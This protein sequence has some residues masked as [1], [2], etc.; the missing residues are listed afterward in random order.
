LKIQGFIVSDA[1]LG[2]R[3]FAEHQEKLS[4]WIADGS[5][6]AKSSVT[7]GLDNA[8]EGFIGMLAGKNFGKAVL[9]IAPLE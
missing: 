3:Y 1:N 8:A 7:K 6:K 2:P 5:F 9:E 4:S